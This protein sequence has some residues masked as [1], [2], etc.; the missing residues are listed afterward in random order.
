MQAEPGAIEEGGQ[1][2]NPRWV[3]SGWTIFNNKGKP[4]RQYEPFFSD[5]LQF[6]FTKV[7]G[8]SSILFYDPVERVVAKGRGVGKRHALDGRVRDVPFVPERDVL[9]GRLDVGAD[10]AC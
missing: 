3:G 1:E 9:E 7:V 4:V 6:E 2:V 5:T 8:V 10:E